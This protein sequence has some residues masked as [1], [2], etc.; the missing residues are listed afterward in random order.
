[1]S[2]TFEEEKVKKA[3]DHM[4]RFLGIKTL[5]GLNFVDIGC[6]SGIHSLAAVLAGAES[7]TSFDFDKDSVE[8]TK[9]LRKL[10][11]TPENWKVLHGSILDSDFVGQLEISL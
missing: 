11:G 10:Y 9:S 2:S 1:M 3:S 8:A 4:L 7:V 6:G 5:K